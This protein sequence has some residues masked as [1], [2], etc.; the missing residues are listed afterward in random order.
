[1]DKEITFRRVS[2]PN[3]R[4][5]KWG[6]PVVFLFL[7]LVV[8]LSL[9]FLIFSGNSGQSGSVISEENQQEF[10]DPSAIIRF[11]IEIIN[12]EHLDS[13]RQFISNIYDET[14]ELDGIRS[15]TINDGEYARIIFEEPLSSEN[16][17]TIYP[18]VVSGTPRVEVYEKDGNDLIAEF[19]AINDNEYN[20]V[21]LMNLKGSQDTFNLRIL[22][23]SLEFD[24]IIDPEEKFYKLKK[25][26]GAEK[27][28][29]NI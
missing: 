22:D 4:K 15:E 1:M 6:K 3:E 18:K 28:F 21:L 16:D 10:S 27:Y 13:S 20:K 9:I 25:N 26:F 12:A 14:K 19:T 2:F 5:F 7:G 23:G 29:P 8:F 24:H 11:V 17:I